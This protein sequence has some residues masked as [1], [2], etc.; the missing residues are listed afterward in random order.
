MYM[1]IYDLEVGMEA[2][3]VFLVGLYELMLVRGYVWNHEIYVWPG[4]W[5]ELM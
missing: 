4:G 1:C 5:Y 2:L 3:Y